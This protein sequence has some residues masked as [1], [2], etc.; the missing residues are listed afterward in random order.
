MPKSLRL[1]LRLSLAAAAAAAP[2]SAR[3]CD[4]IWSLSYWASLALGAS[5]EPIYVISTPAGATIL[6]IDREERVGE[7]T[8]SLAKASPFPLNPCALN[9]VRVVINGARWR[10]LSTCKARPNYL[11][12]RTR[13][14]EL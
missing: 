9:R 11:G 3:A 7:T 4:S 14:C 1:C 8:A 10:L 2:Q 13:H 12:H 5:S 6:D